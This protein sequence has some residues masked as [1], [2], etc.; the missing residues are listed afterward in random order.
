MQNTDCYV[1]DVNM[2]GGSTQLVKDGFTALE[3]AGGKIGC[4]I[5]E[6]KPRH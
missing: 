1:N 6:K 4:R 5:N 3:V 2:M